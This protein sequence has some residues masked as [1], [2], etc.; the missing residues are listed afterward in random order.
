MARGPSLTRRIPWK[1]SPV[2]FAGLAA[3]STVALERPATARLQL[4]IRSLGGTIETN[5]PVDTIESLPAAQ[6][7]LLDLTPRQVIRIASKRLP[8]KCRVGFPAT[9]H[10]GGSAEEIEVGERAAWIGND[11]GAPFVLLAQPSLFDPARG[12]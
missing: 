7:V 8:E 5:A 12:T 10:P 2:A 9:L 11:T 3:H 1:P 6:A 4:I